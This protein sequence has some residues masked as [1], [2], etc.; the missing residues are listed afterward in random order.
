MNAT[1]L[2][3][4][5]RWRLLHNTLRNLVHHSLIRLVTIVLCSLLIWGV[6]F[7][8]SYLGFHELKYKWNLPLD[9]SILDV[10]FVLLFSTLT[11]MLIFSTAII[12]YS[13]LFASPEATFLLGA[14]VPADQVFAYKYQGAVAFGSWAFVLL[15]SPILIA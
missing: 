4:W 3:T 13:S 10:L 1:G 9:N 12:L 14:P 11:L 7:A 5:L 15:A 6:V 8:G 2:F